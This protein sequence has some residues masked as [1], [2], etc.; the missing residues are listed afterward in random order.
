[1]CLRKMLSVVKWEKFASSSSVS[2]WDVSVVCSHAWTF[3][4]NPSGRQ[5][6][7]QLAS[8]F[9]R[10][11]KPE[12]RKLFIPS[13]HLITVHERWLHCPQKLNKGLYF[14]WAEYVIHSAGFGKEHPSAQNKA[15]EQSVVVSGAKGVS[16]HYHHLLR[17]LCCCSSGCYSAL[18]GWAVVRWKPH[19]P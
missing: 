5:S 7:N 12:Q 17:P 11:L 6:G 9:N 14:D 8:A 3:P 1:M 10:K 19:S 4:A 2:I 13:V 16:Q 18:D 15:H